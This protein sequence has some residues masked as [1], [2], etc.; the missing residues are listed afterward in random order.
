MAE[1][2]GHVFLKKDAEALGAALGLALT[3]AAAGVR[4]AARASFAQFNAE[5]P[6]RANKLFERSDGRTQKA[7]AEAV[8]ALKAAKDDGVRAPPPGGASFAEDKVPSAPLPPPQ[9]SGQSTPRSAKGS[10]AGGRGPGGAAAAVGNAAA[11]ASG[12]RAT[13]AAASPGKAKKGAAAA[14]VAPADAAAAAVMPPPLRVATATARDAEA[15]VP[16]VVAYR[17]SLGACPPRGGEREVAGFLRDRLGKGDVV[18]FMA[19]SDHDGGAGGGSGGPCGFALCHP[20]FSTLTLSP[21]WQVADLY[22]SEAHRRRGVAAALLA[23]CEAGARGAGATSLSLEFS[24]AGKVTTAL[25]EGRGFARDPDAKRFD[26]F[27]AAP[28]KR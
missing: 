20:S 16:L 3:D 10:G 18:A 15:L 14:E 25:A 11:K 2:W 27:L 19:F 26:L 1:D 4:A 24:G 9:T 28:G 22:V 23:A 5:F 12:G 8:L 13:T 17:T 21:A 6:E 7:L